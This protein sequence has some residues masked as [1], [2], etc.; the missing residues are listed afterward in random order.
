MRGDLLDLGFRAFNE[1]CSVLIVKCLEIT[2]YTYSNRW[3]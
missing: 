1:Q 2:H 3:Q